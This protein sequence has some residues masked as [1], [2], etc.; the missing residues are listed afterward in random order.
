MSRLIR[1]DALFP[2]PRWKKGLLFRLCGAPHNRKN[3]LF[4]WTEAGAKY[5]GIVQSLLATCR[6]QGIDPYVYLVDVLQR[7][8][9]HPAVEVAS[10][11]PRLWKGLFAENPLRSDLAGKH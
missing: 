2:P 10:L 6:V 5:V 8:D 9:T 3:W 1:I 4:C 7:I 11:T